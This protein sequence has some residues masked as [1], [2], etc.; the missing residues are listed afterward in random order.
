MCGEYKNFLNLKFTIIV[1]SQVLCACLYVDNP[2]ILGYKSKTTIVLGTVPRDT[3]ARN[4]IA[5]INHLDVT[6]IKL[7]DK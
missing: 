6:E 7:Y 2:F 3:L 4:R 5:Y 1:L